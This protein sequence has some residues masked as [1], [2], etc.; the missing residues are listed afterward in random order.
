MIHHLVVSNKIYRDLYMHCQFVNALNNKMDRKFSPNTKIN[1]AP[2]V[3]YTI[4]NYYI[5]HAIPYRW[6]CLLNAFEHIVHTYFRSSLWVSLC[7][8]KADAFPKTLLQT[9][10]DKQ[11]WKKVW[12]LM[13]NLVI[14]TR[15]YIERGREKCLY[16]C[17]SRNK[18]E[19]WW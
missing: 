10:K 15:A 5:H 12:D 8:A 13:Q 18:F 6:S 1:S 14:N 17:M 19:Y 11:I 16:V 7:L 3:C 2:N 4:I 9:W